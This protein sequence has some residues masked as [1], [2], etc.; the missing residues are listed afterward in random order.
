[1]MFVEAVVYCR[2]FHK[3]FKQNI[4]FL[5]TSLQKSIKKLQTDEQ[6]M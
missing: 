1:M 3:V 2:T 4:H 5:F 6:N